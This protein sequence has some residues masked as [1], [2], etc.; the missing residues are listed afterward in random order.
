MKGSGLRDEDLRI[1]KLSVDCFRKDSD[2]MLI[3]KTNPRILKVQVSYSH[4]RP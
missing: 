4:M 3:G 1:R 2:H